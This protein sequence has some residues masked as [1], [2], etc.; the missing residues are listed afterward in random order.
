LLP[1]NVFGGSPAD[2]SSALLEAVVAAVGDEP[3]LSG[4]D[5]PALEERGAGALQGDADGVAGRRR[6]DGG[7]DGAVDR[8]GDV[9]DLG[10]GARA[11]RP[12][13]RVA[14]R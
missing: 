6:F 13:D 4:G 10:A 8:R 11:R 3:I 1:W 5:R 14:T 12:Q 9:D 2:L 7:L